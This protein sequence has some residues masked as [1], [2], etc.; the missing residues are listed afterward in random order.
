MGLLLRRW[1]MPRLLSLRQWDLCAVLPGGALPPIPGLCRKSGG[2]G[3]VP[4]RS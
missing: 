1:E 2:E 3:W 4:R